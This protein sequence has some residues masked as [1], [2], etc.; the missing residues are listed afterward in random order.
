MSEY[1]WEGEAQV[2][3]IWGNPGNPNFH[4]TLSSIHRKMIC[5]GALDSLTAPALRKSYFCLAQ[6]HDLGDLA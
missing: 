4:S 6:V 2:S 5:D 1:E 3:R